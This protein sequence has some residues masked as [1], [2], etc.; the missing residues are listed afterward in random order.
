MVVIFIAPAKVSLKF[1]WFKLW[2][3]MM[4]RR[5]VVSDSCDKNEQWSNGTMTEQWSDGAMT[6]QWINGAMDQWSNDGA[7]EQ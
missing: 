4:R 6:E 2:H 5:S 1:D 3:I 7:M